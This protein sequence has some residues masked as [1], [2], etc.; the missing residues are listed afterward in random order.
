MGVGG[1]WMKSG[2]RGQQRISL[3]YCGGL[4]TKMEKRKEKINEE[5]QRYAENIDN[6]K[7]IKGVCRK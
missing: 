5:Y 3:V 2:L 1:G 7:V 6:Q 4:D